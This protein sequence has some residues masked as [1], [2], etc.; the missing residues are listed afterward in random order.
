VDLIEQGCKSMV[1]QIEDFAHDRFPGVG[2]AAKRAAVLKIADHVRDNQ[3]DCVAAFRDQTGIAA[4]PAMCDEDGNGADYTSLLEDGSWSFDPDGLVSLVELSVARAEWH[5]LH[6]LGPDDGA[7]EECESAD[8]NP[9]LR[10]AAH[11]LIGSAR[12]IGRLLMAS[13]CL[14]LA[15]PGPP[16]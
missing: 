12:W 14:G 15:R 2:N 4:M 10:T 7:L 8:D 13:A 5:G 11:A 6:P 16:S 9:G 1:G 3:A